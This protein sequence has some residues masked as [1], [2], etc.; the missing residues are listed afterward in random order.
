[1]EEHS[2]GGIIVTKR[3]GVWNVLILKDMNNNWTFPKGLIDPGETAEVAAIREIQE[4]TGVT[5]IELKEKLQEI[6]YWYVRNGQK[7]HKTVSY[8]LFLSPGNEDLVPQTEEGITE[9]R[10]VPLPAALDMI[11]Y[12]KTNTALLQR[13]DMIL[14]TLNT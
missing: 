14:S 9:I 7:I 11:G 4:E 3:N 10:W 6:T 1:M 12:P 8:F 2:A 5:T 13:C